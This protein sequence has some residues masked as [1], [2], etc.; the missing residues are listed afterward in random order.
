MKLTKEE[1]RQL[2][3]DGLKKRKTHKI[4]METEWDRYISKRNTK[5][6]INKMKQ[7]K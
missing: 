1:F 5:Y 4:R 6:F 7:K 3:L 2:L